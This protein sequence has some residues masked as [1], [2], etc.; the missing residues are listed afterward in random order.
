MF[1][2]IKKFEEELAEFCGAPYA[3]MTDCCTH[4]IEMCL[5]F[6]CVDQTKFTAHTYLSIPMLMYQL[7]IKFEL[8]EESWTGEYR[9]HGTNIWDS[10]RRLERGMYRPGQVQCLSFGNGKP[11]QIGKAGAILT[12]DVEVYDQL[13]MMRSDGRDLRIT[14]WQNQQ[15]FKQGYHY[16]PS[17]EACQQ[18]I[19]LLPQVNQKPKYQQYPDLRTLD[20]FA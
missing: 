5:R 1:E 12:D 16:C 8:Q 9:F 4:A 10:A 19:D 13:S 14:P 7:G 3:I 18:G 20:Y 6:D 2:K 11:L 17:L 15:T